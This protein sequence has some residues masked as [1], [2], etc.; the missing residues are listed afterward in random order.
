MRRPQA[1]TRDR[2]TPTNGLLDRQGHGCFYS[3]TG[4]PQAPTYPASEA[5]GLGRGLPHF[6]GKSAIFVGAAEKQAP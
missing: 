2:P 1:G 3:G 4:A 5:L 6:E